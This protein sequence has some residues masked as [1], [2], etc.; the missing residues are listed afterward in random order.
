MPQENTSPPLNQMIIGLLPGY[1]RF[2]NPIV[3]RSTYQ[4]IALFENQ[5]KILALLELKGAHSPTDISRMLSIQKGSLTRMV[6]SLTT[7][8][9][10]GR[11][12][13]EHD[14]RTYI[15]SLTPAGRDFLTGHHQACDKRLTQLFTGMS[16]E[17]QQQVAEGL[18]TLNLW[19]EQQ[20]EQD[21]RR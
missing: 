3:N 8:G 13:V 11:T 15:L 10:L 21:E 18:R 1:Y 6:R 2:I 4:G 9:L 20:E 14:E 17:E 19:L 7:L 5:I 12:K 16:F